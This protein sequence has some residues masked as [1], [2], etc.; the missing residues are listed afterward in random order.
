MKAGDY[1]AIILAAGFS[2]R[3]GQ[4]KPLL[5]LGKETIT[6]R[7]VA[8]YLQ[9]GVDVYLVVGYRQEELRA[10]TRARNIRV[11]ANPDYPRGMFTG[12]LAGLRSLEAGYRGAFVNPVDIPLVSPATIRKLI[13]VAG[14]QPDRV[15]RPVFHGE[16]GHPPLIPAA[17]FPAI[18]AAGP[19][20]NLK[21]ILNN[22][23]AITI[24]VRVP[25]RNILFDLDEPADYQELLRRSRHRK[26]GPGRAGG[27]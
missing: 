16:R 19:D 23:S 18:L 15:L 4:F 17:V 22:Y 7:L 1:A 6:D 26:A 13:R 24:E 20:E 9:N 27:S 21:S 10:A 2:S 8:V 5:P 11:V 12:V 14:E 3:M 25:D